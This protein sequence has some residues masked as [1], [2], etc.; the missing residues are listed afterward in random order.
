MFSTATERMRALVAGKRVRLV[1][2]VSQTDRYGRLL[3]YVYAGDIFVNAVM[4]SEGYANAATYPPDV[5]HAAEFAALE[6]SAR[7][8]KR[9]LWAGGCPP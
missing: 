1:R 4:V 9:G 2:D 5:A 8:A 7:I 3:R 6:R